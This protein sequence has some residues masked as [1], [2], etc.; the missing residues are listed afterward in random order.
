[1]KAGK[2]GK[3]DKP[4]QQVNKETSGTSGEDSWHGYW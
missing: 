1:L 4:G 3:A 2:T